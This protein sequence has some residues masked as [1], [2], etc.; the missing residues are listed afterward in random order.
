[1]SWEVC[2]RVVV[3]RSFLPRSQEREK[4]RMALNQIWTIKSQSPSDPSNH[5]S[6]I[7]LSPGYYG[8][9]AS[10]SNESIGRSVRCHTLGSSW[11]DQTFS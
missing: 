3:E 9:D 10:K 7:W 6:N 2:L 5:G 11:C 4:L 1:M 8:H